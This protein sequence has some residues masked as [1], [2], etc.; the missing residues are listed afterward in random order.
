MTHMEYTLAA[1]AVAAIAVAALAAAAAAEAAAA[2][3]VAAV[4]VAAYLEPTAVL[5][6][7][8]LI[9]HCSNLSSYALLFEAVTQC[10]YH[11][12]IQNDY[13]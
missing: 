11:I 3:A 2:A 9:R 7:V 6:T 5:T 8:A 4:A 13:S 1:A 10:I 12:S